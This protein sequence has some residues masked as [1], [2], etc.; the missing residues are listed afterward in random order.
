[1]SKRL[2]RYAWITAFQH[3]AFALSLIY[4]HEIMERAPSFRFI[5]TNVTWLPWAVAFMAVGVLM[6]IAVIVRSDIYVRLLGVA[7]A[8]LCAVWAINFALSFAF[9]KGRVTPIAIVLYAGLALKD[10]TILWIPMS[11]EM[12][13]C[14]EN[15][16]VKRLTANARSSK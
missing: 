8:S 5:F 13:K 1:M 9:D 2:R 4:A 10:F 16:V 3:T 11:D 15:G 14:L 6:T 12:D 7:S